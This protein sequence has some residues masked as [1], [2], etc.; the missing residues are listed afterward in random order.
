MAKKK[1]TTYGNMIRLMDQMQ[2]KIK[3]ERERMAGVM[4]AAL[5]DDQTAVKLGDYSDTDLRRIMSILSVSGYIDEC[6]KM[7]EAEKQAKHSQ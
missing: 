6:I 3:K 4:A 7:L 2:V 1:Q 5:L